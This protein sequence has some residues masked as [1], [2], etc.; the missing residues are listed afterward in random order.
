MNHDVINFS[1]WTYGGQSGGP[2]YIETEEEKTVIAIQSGKTQTYSV[3]QRINTD[4]L[5]F[6]FNNPYL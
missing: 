2:A 3:G 6:A 1:T 5:H 4:V